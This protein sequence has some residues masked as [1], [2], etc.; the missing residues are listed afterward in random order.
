M[1][2][3]VDNRLLLQCKKIKTFLVK[4]RKFPMTVNFNITFKPFSLPEKKVLNARISELLYNNKI[5]RKEVK[6]L[7]N[8]V[9]IMEMNRSLNNKDC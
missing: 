6:N 2:T 8:I 3:K 7:E 4:K 1:K 9:E 5:L